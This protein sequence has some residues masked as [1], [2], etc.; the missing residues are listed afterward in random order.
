MLDAFPDG[1]FFVPLAALTDPDLVPS[2]VAGALGLR[3]EGL[4]SGQFGMSGIDTGIRC[5]T[6]G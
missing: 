4:S 1:V 6:A 5:E 2:A 3:E